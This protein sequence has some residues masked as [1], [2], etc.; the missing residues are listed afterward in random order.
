M[1]EKRIDKHWEQSGE[2]SR[3]ERGWTTERV[4]MTC[5]MTDE[6]H[7]ESWGQGANTGRDLEHDHHSKCLNLC[8]RTTISPAQ[9]R[10]V[11]RQGEATIS[12]SSSYVCTSILLTTMLL[13]HRGS[14][15]N[16]IEQE[17]RASQRI[18][19]LESQ[20]EEAKR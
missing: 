19:D 16:R 18:V 15:F 8:R 1:I 7:I 9:D 20:L 14:L 11:L 13:P 10:R 5:E 3:G 12:F 17:A 2:R 6:E 4:N